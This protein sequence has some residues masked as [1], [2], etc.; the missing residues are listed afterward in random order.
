MQ[1]KDIL[2][3]TTEI[4]QNYLTYQA[5]KLIIEQLS[6]TNPGE[7]IWLRK[8]S[9]GGKLQDGE[10]YIQELMS[11]VQGKQLVMRILAVRDD[12]AEQVLEYIP[13][14]VSTSIKQANLEHRRRLLERLTQ[15]SEPAD[16]L[17]TE[18]DANESSDENK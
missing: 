4:V 12:L 18:L 1:P 8:Y 2:R 10:N 6:E 7:A 14:M 15:S 17:D 5:V 9:S 16:N 11:E 13:E 3:D